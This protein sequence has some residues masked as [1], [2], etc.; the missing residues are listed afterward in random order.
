VVLSGELFLFT[1]TVALLGFLIGSFLN[2]VI[3]RIPMMMFREWTTEA[4][5]FLIEKGYVSES[6]LTIPEQKNAYNLVVPNSACPVCNH[7]IRWYENIPILSYLWL[8]GKCSDCK[9]PI[10]IRYPLVELLTGIVFGYT[11][12]RFGLTPLTGFLLVLSCL[13]IAMTF[14]D[15][16]HKLL[17]D[18]LT[19]MALWLGIV[20]SL[21]GLTIPLEQAI[22]GTMAGYLSL[23][24]VYWGFKLLTGK[25]GMGYGDFKLLAAFGA[26]LGWEPLIVLILMASLSGVI[27][28]VTLMA[29]KVL[30][31][32]ESI[33]FGPYLAIGGW[34]T[35]YFQD[36][37]VAWVLAPY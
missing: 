16:D 28:S 12:Y 27:L 13:L 30:K 8:R 19:Y 31:R 17:P 1:L 33:P 36:T 29:T 15:I 11:A 21:A 5:Q 23:W 26:W 14:I 37:L 34:I 18:S 3:H 22:I 32:G 10:S 25:E 9:T 4:S 35:L 24:S 7:Q 2:V 20:A 6:A